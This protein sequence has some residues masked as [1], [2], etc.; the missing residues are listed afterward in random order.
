MSEKLT[1]TGFHCRLSHIAIIE[2]GGIRGYA[3]LKGKIRNLLDAELPF[4]LIE[5][6][7]IAKG[8]IL[9]ECDKPEDFKEVEAIFD[10]LCPRI[11]D[12]AR[13]LASN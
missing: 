5:A 13:E 4:S 10:E 8:R 6:A 12:L 9:A 3:L 7:S 2:T 11:D 1:T